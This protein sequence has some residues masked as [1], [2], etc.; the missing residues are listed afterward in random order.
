MV[1]KIGDQVYLNGRCSRL[2]CELVQ[3]S[4][5]APPV[6]GGAMSRDGGATCDRLLFV[7]IRH[8]RS[9]TATSSLLR[10]LVDKIFHLTD[11]SIDLNCT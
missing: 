1:F 9:H 6:E 5:G 3:N 7:M 2:K 8:H 10:H 4:E 11:P